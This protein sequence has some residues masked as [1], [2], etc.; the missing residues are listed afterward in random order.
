L[1]IVAFI[2]YATQYTQK[3]NMSVGI[4]KAPSLLF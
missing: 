2:A 4:V 1:A 3:I